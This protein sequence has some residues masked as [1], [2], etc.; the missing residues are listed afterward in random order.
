MTAIDNAANKETSK[1]GEKAN[2]LMQ[3]VSKTILKPIDSVFDG[4]LKSVESAGLT[5]QIQ[6]PHY[7]NQDFFWWNVSK[8]FFNYEIFGSENVPP[9]GQPA[10]FC[11]NHQS[12]FDPL[13]YGVAVT[14]YSRRI[15]HIMAKIE[16]FETP[17]INAY[18]RWI[19]AFPVRRGEHDEKAYSTAIEFLKKGELVGMFPEGTLNGGGFNFLEPK[20]G[21]A[22]MAIEAQVP[23]IPVGLTGTDKIFPKGA[24]FPN[25]NARLLAKIGEPIHVHEKYFG[26]EPAH[27]E[28]KGIMQSVMEKIKGLLQY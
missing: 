11:V 2:P 14:H 17:L 16:L 8:S 3:F 7:L 19:Y 10:V 21:A 15:L 22:K 23:I 25:F 4:M 13:L 18:I 12:L 24:K 9:E 1:E 6:Y 5:K 26:K 20:I 27:D 28:L